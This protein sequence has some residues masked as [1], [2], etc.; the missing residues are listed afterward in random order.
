M[1][2]IAMKELNFNLDIVRTP[3]RQIFV[4][5]DI[6]PYIVKDRT[7]SDTE[8]GGARDAKRNIKN[9]VLQKL[10][11]YLSEDPEEV[12]VILRLDGV[13]RFKDETIADI[14]SADVEVVECYSNQVIN[15]VLA[16]ISQRIGKPLENKGLFIPTTT[17]LNDFANEII[18]LV[19]QGVYKFKTAEF[20]N[21]ATK[22]AE[23]FIDEAK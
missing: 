15:N 10:A 9:V 16:Q 1:E 6:I 2:A 18:M 14:H 23:T 22:M 12:P 20:D 11:T 7:S 21:D 17:S 13:P 3:D 5:K 4:S 8:R 19:K